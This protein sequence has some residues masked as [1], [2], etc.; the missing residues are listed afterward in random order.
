MTEN[1]YILQER[2]VHDKRSIRVKLTPKGLDLCK[3]LDEMFVRHEEKLRS[4]G[5]EDLI[6]SI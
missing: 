6:L 1:E 5:I 4:I 2:S 3:T